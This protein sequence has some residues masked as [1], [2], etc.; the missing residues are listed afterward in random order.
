MAEIKKYE[1]M[2][3]RIKECRIK[4]GLSVDEAA[5][6][7]QVKKTVYLSYEAGKKNM[8]ISK[9]LLLSRLFH[10]STDYLLGS[11]DTRWPPV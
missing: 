7:M 11:I 1:R 10:V 6:I 8:K 3:K 5:T 9:L 2:S 4:A